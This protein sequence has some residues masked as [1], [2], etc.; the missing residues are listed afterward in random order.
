MTNG[1]HK[2]V[3]GEADVSL[4][5][6]TAYPATHPRSLENV[7]ALLH[8]QVDAFLKAEPEDDV[9]RRTQD[10]T[11]ISMQVIE[12]ALL[13][14]EFSA[15]SLS[16]NGGKDCLVLLII[17]LA[18]LHAHFSS[19]R[20]KNGTHKPGEFPKSIPSI[21]AKAPDPF[22]AVS[23]FVEYSSRLYHLDLAHIFTNPGPG[24]KEKSHSNPPPTT[25]PSAQPI[26]NATTEPKN[27]PLSRVTSHSDKPT[28]S[29]RDA[30]A[31]YLRSNPSVRAIFVG[32]RRT[33]PHG[34]HL[35]HFDPT[36]HN[37]PD[38]MRV[39]PVIDWHLS[40]IWCFLRSPFL[41]DLGESEKEGNGV[42]DGESDGFG[43]GKGGLR[44]CAMYDEGY[45]SLGGINDTVRNP[46]LKYIDEDGRERYK[47]AYEMTWDEGE[48]LGRE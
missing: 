4:S 26:E 33:D 14:Y 3:N 16:Y 32:T 8:G 46:K 9:T 30:F 27:V 12:K 39:H 1:L 21:Y 18:V 45:T 25:P 40:E 6:P 38:F 41:T 2:M 47:P 15:L 44:Y 34:G 10:Q 42:A 29:F 48:R 35:T 23:H 19:K 37:W 5:H 20:S 13:D 43:R 11:R 36:D 22:H 24:K 17:Y 7:C 31:L 28:V